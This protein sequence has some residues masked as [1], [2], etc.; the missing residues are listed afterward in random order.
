MDKDLALNL[1]EN[2]VAELVEEDLFFSAMRDKNIP[3][4]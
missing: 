2:V 4:L 1:Y 3:D